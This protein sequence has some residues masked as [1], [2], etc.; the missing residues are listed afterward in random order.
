MLSDLIRNYRLSLVILLSFICSPCIAETYY[1]AT[2]GDNDNPG[3]QQKPIQTVSKAVALAKPGDTIFVRGGTYNLSD[4]IELEKSGTASTSIGLWAFDSEQPI[5]DASHC[6]DGID[7][8]GDFWHL[9][10]LIIEKANGKG[11]RLEGNN[12]IIE[13]CR[14]RENSD[15]GLKMDEGASGNLVLNCDSYRN[16]NKPYGDDADGFAAKHGLGKGNAFKG[17]RAWNNSDD[18]FDLMEAGNAIV[19]ENCWSWSNGKN[20]WRSSRFDGNGVGYKLGEKDGA[21]VVTHCLA[22]EN[23]SS[24]FNVQEN[25]SGVIL[26]NNTAWNNGTNYLFDDAHPHKLRN[27]TSFDGQVVMH[28]GIDHT[29][30]SWNV[31][32]MVTVEDFLSLDDSAMDGERGSDGSLPKS[33]FLKLAPGSVL[34]DAGIDVGIKFE[35]SAPDLGAFESGKLRKVL[36]EQED[37]EPNTEGDGLGPAP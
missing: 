29:N 26:K 13:Q 3:T 37:A 19:L 28:R 2:D 17:C 21:H 25:I 16:Y 20:I 15:S 18:G 32:L 22:W 24:G 27:N 4:T 6:D 30:N 36:K 9:K 5:F 8:G 11:I 31:N 33:D 12:N 35:G 34:I 10:G 23:G 1:V 7:L 14:F